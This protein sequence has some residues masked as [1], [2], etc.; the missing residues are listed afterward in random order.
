MRL[1]G[2]GIA[3]EGICRCGHHAED[4]E[5]NAI[6]IGAC[7]FWG[8][9]ERAGLD[10]KGWPHCDR[11]LDADEVDPFRAEHWAIRNRRSSQPSHRDATRLRQAFANVASGS[12]RERYR[13]TLKALE[14]HARAA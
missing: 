5:R 10:G 1:Q 12:D 14:R 7:E 13:P 9:D 6:G 4:H 8:S 11:F 3:A 2:Y